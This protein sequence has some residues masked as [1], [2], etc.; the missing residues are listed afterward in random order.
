MSLDQEIG[1]FFADYAAAF[2]RGDVDAVCGM[3]V[4]PA[5][6]VAA[7]AN[8]A[9]DEATFRAGFGK[10]L[11]RQRKLG[12]EGS[13]CALVSCAPLYPDVAEARVRYTLRGGDGAPLLA[14]E[15]VYLLRRTPAGWRFAA[16]VQDGEAAAWAALGR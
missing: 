1:A 5:L 13:T 16:A 7:A 14:W 2:T 15:H 12:A 6:F 3:W 11:T 10:V 4:F 8:A 9:S